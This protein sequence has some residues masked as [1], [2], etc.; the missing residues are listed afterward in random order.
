MEKEKEKEKMKKV[1]A[2]Y[3]DINWNKLNKKATIW[4]NNNYKIFKIN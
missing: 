1:I 2:L 4:K 3:F